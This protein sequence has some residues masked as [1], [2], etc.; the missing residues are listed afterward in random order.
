MA[1]GAFLVGYFCLD[2]AADIGSRDAQDFGVL[3]LE[4]K[5]GAIPVVPPDPGQGL[6]RAILERDLVRLCCHTDH[7]RSPFTLIGTG[8]FLPDSQPVQAHEGEWRVAGWLGRVRFTQ[9]ERRSLAWSQMSIKAWHLY[10]RRCHRRGSTASKASLR[11]VG[12]ED[13]M[14]SHLSSGPGG[15]GGDDRCCTSA[16]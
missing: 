7:L 10:R 6:S 13:V 4:D 3:V 15:P 14:T 2:D 5:E 12:K 11:L 1:S 8:F 16:W 9:I